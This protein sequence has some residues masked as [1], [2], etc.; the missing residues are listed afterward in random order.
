MSVATFE[1]FTSSLSLRETLVTAFLAGAVSLAVWEIWATVFAPLYMGGELQPVGLV[2]SALGIGDQTF[3]AYFAASSGA[4]GNAVANAI[5]LV[6][7]LLL[8]PLGY[9]LIAR[10]VAGVVLPRLS[11]LAVGAVY[12]VALY[13][14]AMY[15]MAHFFAGFPPF[16]GFNPLS[17][18]SL[19]GHVALGLAIAGVVE[20]R[21]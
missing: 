3:A 12:G 17:Q 9:L 4:V 8:Y 1:K 14:F 6:T 19:I 16:F 18:A 5:H 7:G 2:K 11:W 20:A 10:P 13:V 21:D 15:I